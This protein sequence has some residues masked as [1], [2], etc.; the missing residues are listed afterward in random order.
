VKGESRDG[1]GTMGGQRSQGWETVVTG[2]LQG[3]SGLG[4]RGRRVIWVK[5]VKEVRSLPPASVERR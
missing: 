3:G 4:G 2:S 5:N 1:G